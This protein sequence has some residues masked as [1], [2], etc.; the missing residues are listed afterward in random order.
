M[1]ILASRRRLTAKNKGRPE[2]RPSPA[3]HRR[4]SGRWAAIFGQVG[5]EAVGVEFTSAISRA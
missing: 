5:L 4:R 2:G 1:M 3:R